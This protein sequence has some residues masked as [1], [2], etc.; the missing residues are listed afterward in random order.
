MVSDRRRPW[1]NETSEA[2]PLRCAYVQPFRCK[3]NWV[4]SPTLGEARGSVRLLLN[5]NH[6]ISTTAFRAG[7]PDPTEKEQLRL[8][9]WSSGCKCDCG[10]VPGSGEVMLGFFRFFEYFSVVAR[11][12]EMC[13]VYDNSLTTYYM[14]LNHKLRKMSFLNGRSM[15]HDVMCTED[16]FNVWIKMYGDIIFIPLIKLGASTYAFV[17]LM[18]PVAISILLHHQLIVIHPEL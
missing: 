7:A 13:T 12:L 9:R 14:G 3:E 16:Y 11:S 18:N 8:P 6:P 10:K 4:S 17:L 2:L 15:S 1:T 5:K